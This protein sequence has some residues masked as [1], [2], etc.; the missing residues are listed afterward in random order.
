MT[1]FAEDI[2]AGTLIHEAQEFGRLLEFAP[3]ISPE[4]LVSANLKN[5]EL[6]CDPTDQVEYINSRLHLSERGPVLLTPPKQRL[7]NWLLCSQYVMK[8]VVQKAGRFNTDLVLS[9]GTHEGTT[10][11]L[12][13]LL[14]HPEEISRLM[15]RSPEK[16]YTLS[17]DATHI[18]AANGAKSVNGIL[19]HSHTTAGSEIRV[20]EPF[21]AFAPWAAEVAI[22]AI[23]HHQPIKPK[24]APG[25]KFGQ[26]T[27][28]DDEDEEQDESQ[29]A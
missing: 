27:Y 15:S 23:I 24:A 25:E 7:A 5:A 13:A 4:K 28:D 19:D 29:S 9:I 1:S 6:R 11:A 18:I 14:S 3:T 12:A 26:T 22:P 17:D 8:Y 16:F 2:E 20:S 10:L 21:A